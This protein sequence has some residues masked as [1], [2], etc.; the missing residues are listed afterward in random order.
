[1]IWN[2]FLFI[3]RQHGRHG[4]KDLDASRGGHKHDSVRNQKQR[5]ILLIQI[6]QV[7]ETV[8]KNAWLTGPENVRARERDCGT[9]WGL[10]A[11]YPEPCWRY[12]PQI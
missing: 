9:K 10:T 1:M 5:D 3:E 7:I 6:Q 11:F 12:N 8:P 2:G 4:V